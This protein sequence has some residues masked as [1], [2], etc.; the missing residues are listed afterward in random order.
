MTAGEA[1]QVLQ[2]CFA[3]Y[4]AAQLNAPADPRT[5]SGTVSLIGWGE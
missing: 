4:R 5:I 2:L 3:V 1:T